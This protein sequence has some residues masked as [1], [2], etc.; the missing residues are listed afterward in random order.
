MKKSLKPEMIGDENPEWN[1][2]TGAM[3]NRHYRK[4]APSDDPSES[5]HYLF[6][7]RVAEMASIS[8]S[9]TSGW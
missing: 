5:M 1:G 9:V 3:K 6:L 2:R 8:G 7:S 4:E